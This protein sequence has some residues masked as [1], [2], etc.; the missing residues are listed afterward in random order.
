MRG[1]S[2]QFGTLII[3]LGT[4]AWLAYANVSAALA[5][6]ATDTLVYSV[7]ADAVL[8]FFGLAFWHYHALGRNAACTVLGLFWLLAAGY[9]CAANIAKLQGEFSASW[10]PV[11]DAETRHAEIMARLDIAINQARDHLKAAQEEALHGKTASIREGAER[12]AREEAD[13]ITKLEIERNV[14]LPAM[15]HPAV[16]HF[17]MGWEPVVPVV[18]L[19]VAQV[20]LWAT[21]NAGG[22]ITPSRDQAMPVINAVPLAD[23]WQPK[24]ADRSNAIRSNVI[25]AGSPVAQ[26]KT[27]LKANKKGADPKVDRDPAVIQSTPADQTNVVALRRLDEPPTPEMIRAMLDRGMSQRAVAEKLGISRPKVQRLL[28]ATLPS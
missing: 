4:T 14:P 11:R 2:W 21:F 3:G 18:L 16:K 26:T 10:Q 7:L 22:P 24:I 19:L 17:I 9:I 5:S 23:P 1:W 20:A 28:A 13:H 6:G 25:Q 12:Q 27:P 15:N 8:F